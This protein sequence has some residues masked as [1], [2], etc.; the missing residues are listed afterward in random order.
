MEIAI[1]IYVLV[2]LGFLGALELIYSRTC[3]THFKKELITAAWMTLNCL[4]F[5]LG[6]LLAAGPTL[7][8]EMMTA[9]LGV[10]V[11]YYTAQAVFARLVYGRSL[12]E[13]FAS[14]DAEREERRRQREAKKTRAVMCPDANE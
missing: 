2:L 13:H 14:K 11:I 8:A 4:L 9:S 7:F 3:M 6:G 12:L 10:I 5:A 1:A